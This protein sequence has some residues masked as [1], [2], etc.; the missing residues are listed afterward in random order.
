MAHMAKMSIVSYPWP[1]VSTLALGVLEDFVRK[2]L[3]GGPGAQE[4]LGDPVATAELQG[5]FFSISKTWF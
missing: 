1:L 5:T 3:L 2:L 4:V